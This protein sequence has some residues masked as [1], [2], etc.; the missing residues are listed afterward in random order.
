MILTVLISIF[1]TIVLGLLIGIL[2]FRDF[3][4]FLAN[5]FIFTVSLVSITAFALGVAIAESRGTGDLPEVVD[6]HAIVAMVAMIA[7][8]L[9]FIALLMKARPNKPK[10]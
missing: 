8:P 2:A 10:E 7:T 6:K 3:K 4:N 5:R 1:A 9:I